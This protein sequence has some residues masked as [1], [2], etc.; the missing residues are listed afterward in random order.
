MSTDPEPAYRTVNRGAWDD[1]SRNG[2]QYTVPVGVDDL[3]RARGSLDPHGWIAWEGIRTVLCLASGGGQQGPLAASLGKRVTVVDL[4]P[5]QLAKDRRTAA[6]LGLDLDTIEADMQDLAPLHGRGF[7]LV[8][9]PVSC[10]YVPDVRQV[11]REVASVIAPG[12]FYLVAQWN[13]TWIQMPETGEWDGA[14]Y[15]LTTPQTPGI[16]V[17]QTRWTIAG[18]DHAITAWLYIHPLGDLV[19]GLLDAGF[20]LLHFRESAA[21][22]PTAAPGS[23]PHLSAWAPPLYRLFARAPL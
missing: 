19:G 17:P 20:T 18:R 4:S 11:Y 16:P 23:L 15:R 2:C 22:D 14:A 13:P 10:C 8:L 6:D 21:A 9:Q 5:E 7:D 1:L 12:G 3:A